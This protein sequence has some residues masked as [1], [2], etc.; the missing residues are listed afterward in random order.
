M[1]YIP[2]RDIS[3]QIKQYDPLLYIKWNEDN[4][5]FEV[6]RRCEKKPMLV[7]PVTRSIY[8]SGAPKTFVQLDERILWWLHAADSWRDPYGKLRHVIWDQRWLNFQDQL[9][10]KQKRDINDRAKD[11]ASSAFAIKVNKLGSKNSAVESYNKRMKR[12]DRQ[13]MMPSRF[14]KPDRQSISNPRVF[15]RSAQNAK[16]FFGK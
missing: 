14:I 3:K 8:F 11:I 7:T 5:Y 9:R 15:Y 16:K 6:W 10:S 2:D 12:L 13:Q 1:F 4:E